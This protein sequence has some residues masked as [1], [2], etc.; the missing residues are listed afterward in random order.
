[1]A[2]SQ[3]GSDCPGRSGAREIVNEARE[4]AVGEEVEHLGGV[5]E[6]DEVAHDRLQ[7]LEEREEVVLVRLPTEEKFAT[8]HAD[9]DAVG[10]HAFFVLTAIFLA[11]GIRPIVAVRRKRATVEVAPWPAPKVEAEK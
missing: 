10:A 4:P 7:A 11:L 9:Y 5:V 6:A 8:W 2:R 3:R 1:V